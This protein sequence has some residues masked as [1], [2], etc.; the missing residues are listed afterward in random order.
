MWKETQVLKRVVHSP[1]ICHGCFSLFT[2]SKT[3]GHSHLCLLLFCCV[4]DGGAADLSQLATLTIKRPAAD[5]ISNHIFHE[6]DAA[7][8]TQ[9]QPVEQLDVL[10]QIVIWVTGLGW[11][12]KKTKKS[13][14]IYS[15]MWLS[16]SGRELRRTLL[17]FVM[18]SVSQ[19]YVEECSLTWCRS[20]C[21]C[22]C[23]TPASP[24]A[25][26]GKQIWFNVL[27]WFYI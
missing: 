22:F 10:Q 16:F 24:Q 4:D 14:V 5:F 7:I 12:F 2:F 19:W 1:Q 23:C 20:T 8:K 21:Y 27:Y 17:N 13:S 18:I 3:E 15:N 11:G 25:V 9:G 6:E 26:R